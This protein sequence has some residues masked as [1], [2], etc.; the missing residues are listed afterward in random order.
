MM[1]QLQAKGLEHAQART[2]SAMYWKDPIPLHSEPLYLLQ[3]V[4]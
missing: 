2:S 1:A 3:S 4:Q